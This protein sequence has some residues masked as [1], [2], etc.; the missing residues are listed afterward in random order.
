MRTIIVNLS[1]LTMVAFYFSCHQANSPSSETGTELSNDGKGQS[2]VQDE[3]SELNVV[4]VAMGSLDHTT[5]VAA[6]KAAGLVDAL[7]NAGPFTVFAPVNAAF[8]ALP[9]GTVENLLKPENKAKLQDI[10]EYHVFVGVIYENMISDGR[11]LNQVN[12]KNVTLGNKDG[13][14]TV[15]DANILGSVTASNGIVYI[16]DKVLLP[17]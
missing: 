16:I 1:I 15:N 12:L 10:L 9:P 11:R 14:I 4:Q 3:A 17:E 7:S 2:A 8:D 13:K 5:L 6:V